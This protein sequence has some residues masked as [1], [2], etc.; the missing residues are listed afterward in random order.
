MNSKLRDY[1]S[2]ETPTALKAEEWAGAE[3]VLPV[4]GHKGLA[5]IRNE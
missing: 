5:F 4:Q 3:R 2:G 1:L